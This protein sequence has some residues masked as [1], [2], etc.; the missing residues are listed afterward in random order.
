MRALLDVNVLIALLDAG[1]VHHR[2]A[3]DWLVVHLER[4]WA[5]CPL[6]Q[7]GCIRILSNAAYPN[8]IPAAQVAERL[9]EAARHPAHAFWPDA[10]SLLEPDRLAWDRLL[11]GRQVTDAYLLAL[12][13]DQGGRLVTLDRGV[14]W[15]AVR[16]ARSPHLVV[17]SPGAQRK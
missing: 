7:N 14:P 15:A 6:T 11:S 3:T 12:A 9:A 4:G 13:V 16:G 1:H 17:L 2:L 8:A 5:S 10:I